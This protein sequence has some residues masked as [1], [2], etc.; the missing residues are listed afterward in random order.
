M[1]YFLYNLLLIVS[2][3]GAVVYYFWRT[4]VARKSDK[5]WRENLGGLPVLSDRPSDR[6]LIWVHAASVG[7]VVATLPVLD[8]L[9]QVAPDVMILLSTITQTGNAVARKSAK[10]VD[11]ICYLPLDFLPF[12]N[13]AISRVRPDA[14]VTVESEMWPNLLNSIARHG[15]PTVMIN[16]CVSDRS[17]RRSR[18]WGWM[19]SWSISNI[20]SFC[21]Q[22]RTDAERMVSLGAK[23]EA[24]K[25]VGSTKFDQEGC[26]LVSGASSA[27][28]TDLGLPEGALV[29]VAG[30]TNPGEDEPVLEAFRR[31]RD[32]FPD[33]RL[34]IAPRQLDRADAIR[35]LIESSGFRCARRTEKGA[36]SEYDVLLLDT[37]G[38]LAAIYGV[39]DVAFVG[40]SLIPKGGH[41]IIQP[42]LQGKPVL[43]GPHTFKTRDV[44]RMALSMGIGFEVHS[45]EELASQSALLLGDPK[46]RREIEA[47]CDRIVSENRGASDRC[48][49][50]ILSRIRQTESAG[51]Q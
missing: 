18:W 17:I 24:V 49:D 34:I 35:S 40:G 32:Q 43:F 27:I 8:R 23:P 21:M 31:M 7:E 11:A 37:Y 19:M 14:L 10:S 4:F 50:A 45:A 1:P 33:L 30:S 3:P 22:T 29:V 26:R 36:V 39:A 15:I 28:R 41:S 20:S 46:K 16:G 48:A 38:E 6:K 5:A 12:V 2:L 13:R 47:A 44:A 25:V 51:V 9:K 42:I